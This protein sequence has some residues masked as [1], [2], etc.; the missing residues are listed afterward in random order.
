M[1]P[2]I[3]ACCSYVDDKQVLRY[4]RLDSYIAVA[5]SFSLL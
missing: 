5:T 1:T 4:I 3:C 2:K